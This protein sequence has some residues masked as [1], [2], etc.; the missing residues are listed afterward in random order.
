MALAFVLQSTHRVHFWCGLGGQHQRQRVT[1]RQT[2]RKY[3]GHEQVRPIIESTFGF[4]AMQEIPVPGIARR[5]LR[6]LSDDAIRH[7]AIK[8]ADLHTAVD[9]QRTWLPTGAAAQRVEIAVGH[10]R[11]NLELQVA[12][13]THQ[14][15]H[16]VRRGGALGHPDALLEQSVADGVCPDRQG[17]LECER[18][19]LA[20][21]MWVD[22]PVAVLVCRKR[23]A[24]AV[25]G[26]RIDRSSHQHHALH[27]WGERR[28]Q[29]AVV[30]PR[31]DAGEGARRV[32]PKAVG[33][34]PFPA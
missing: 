5:V 2:L 28:D 15:V 27:R 29:Q 13:R 7:G 19:D 12:A 17:A 4:L 20:V 21:A 25:V 32:A 8:R 34:E 23:E 1:Y 14:T 31:I 26:C 6:A 33:Y 9:F 22:S 30:S 11:R 3:A 24:M 18:H 16:D 10:Q